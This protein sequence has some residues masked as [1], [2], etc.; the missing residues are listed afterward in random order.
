MDGHSHKICLISRE[1]RENVYSSAIVS[2]IASTI[3]S[4][5]ANHFR[6]LEHREQIRLYK[7]FSNVPDLR[8]M[9]DIFLEAA[10]QR[11]LQHRV[12]LHLVP[13]VRL[14]SRK[15]NRWHTTSHVCLRNATLERSRQQA[16]EQGQTLIIPKDL[17]IKEYA[18]HGP[19]SPITPNVIY[20][21]EL[22][23]QA[24]DCFIVM[25]DLLYIFQFTIGGIKPGLIDFVD[26][27][28]ELPSKD[29]WRF[30]FIVPPTG[31]HEL[32]C[33][34]PQSQKLQP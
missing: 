18:K 9:A 30:V 34:Q 12:T 21:P 7:H 32:I 11:C 31:K 27:Y 24:L 13:M 22:T 2:P 33:S 5:L 23:N 16:V 4:R 19:L 8:A 29:N 10:G 15:R 14:P 1:D 6:T 25:N 17:Q 28:P 20:V 26:K 3:K